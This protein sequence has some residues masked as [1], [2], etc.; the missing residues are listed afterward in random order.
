LYSNTII[1]SSEQRIIIDQQKPIS[2]ASSNITG[3]KALK[4]VS[5]GRAI[6]VTETFNP[7]M[8]AFYYLFG[9]K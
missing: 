4:P 6:N 8:D 7:I 3:E 1:K 9:W 5:I 2:N